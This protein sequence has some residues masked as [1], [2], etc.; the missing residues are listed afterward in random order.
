MRDGLQRRLAVTPTRSTS[1]ATHGALRRRR[2]ALVV[3][4][5]LRGATALNYIP[6]PTYPPVSGTTSLSTK[7]LTSSVDG[8]TGTIPTEL[9]L[10]TAVSLVDFSL[11]ADFTG[12][13]PTQ[14]GRLSRV[15]AY[16]DVSDNW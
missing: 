7:T 4:G 11:Y 6:F 8:Y 16:F 14:L 10:L 13:I 12:T 15:T 1:R 9:G 5:A 3:L 2:L